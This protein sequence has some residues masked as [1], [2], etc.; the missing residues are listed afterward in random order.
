MTNDTQMG[1]D[2]VAESYAER[3]IHELNYKP[4]EYRSSSL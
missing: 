3:F 1:Y 2:R 4:F